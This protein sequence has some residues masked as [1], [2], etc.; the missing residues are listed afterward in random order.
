[1]G[2]KT[3]LLLE[4]TEESLRIKEITKLDLNFI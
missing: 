2:Q 3:F 1:M 4:Q